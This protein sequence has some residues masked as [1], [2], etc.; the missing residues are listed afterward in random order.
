M[1]QSIFEMDALQNSNKMLH[2][3]WSC[4]ELFLVT[5]Q[6]TN[7]R[8]YSVFIVF[9]FLLVISSAILAV[10]LEPIAVLILVFFFFFLWRI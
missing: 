8:I 9:Y 4:V 1:K 3:K 10:A 7:Q 6:Q 5:A 2:T